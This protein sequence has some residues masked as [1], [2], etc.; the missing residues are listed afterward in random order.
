MLVFVV[1]TSELVCPVFQL[2]E[3]RRFSIGVSVSVSA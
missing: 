1:V 3:N 2:W